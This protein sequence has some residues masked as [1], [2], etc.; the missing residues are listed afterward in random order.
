MKM[1]NMF[2][3]PDEYV[4]GFF[5]CVDPCTTSE[6]VDGCVASF[7]IAGAAAL[8][9]VDCQNTSC[10]EPCICEAATGDDACIVCSKQSCCAE[11]VDYSLAPDLEAFESCATPCLDNLCLDE[12]AN[13]YPV[14]GT[15]F[16][17]WSDCA[18]ENCATQ[19]Q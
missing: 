11:L 15:A 7:P 8:D 9:L 10:A 1:S 16:I 2:N 6:C 14:A 3:A 19:C 4:Q 13:S 18:Y 12:C 5:N 17:A